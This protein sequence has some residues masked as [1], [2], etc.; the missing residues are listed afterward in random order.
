M[1]ERHFS[2]FIAVG[3]TA[4]VTLSAYTLF[5][6]SQGYLDRRPIEPPIGSTELT[7]PTSVQASTPASTV[8]R[9]NVTNAPVV[10][11][12]NLR[13]VEPLKR[14]PPTPP[15]RIRQGSAEDTFWKSTPAETA[16][17]NSGSPADS[18]VNAPKTIPLEQ[19]PQFACR[20]QSV[21]GEGGF[22]MWCGDDTR[23]ID[24]KSPFDLAELPP[25]YNDLLGT[26]TCFI[27]VNSQGMPAMIV[28]ATEW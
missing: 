20:L 9:T 8:G 22:G 23:L 18:S 3:L 16:A 10:I 28:C 27:R 2:C 12:E 21:N 11:A 14:T 7:T 15:P 4:L 6:D 5:L 1:K 13:P 19:Q 26:K 25:E 24:S 17:A